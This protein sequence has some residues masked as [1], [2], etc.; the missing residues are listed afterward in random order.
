MWMMRRAMMMNREIVL[1]LCA[2][3]KASMQKFFEGHGILCPI[4]AIEWGCTREWD[5]P[6]GTRGRMVDWFLK[7]ASSNLTDAHGNGLED[8]W[9]KLKSKSKIIGWFAARPSEDGSHLKLG[10]SLCRPDD[11]FNKDIG[12]MKAMECPLKINF[13]WEVEGLEEDQR[14][15]KNKEDWKILDKDHVVYV[16]YWPVSLEE[17]LRRFLKKCRAYYKQFRLEVEEDGEA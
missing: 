16:R 3:R 2:R 6:R 5:E 1:K 4:R 14:F 8:R 9:R 10:F 7:G 12:I 13:L 15:K 17:Q 11:E